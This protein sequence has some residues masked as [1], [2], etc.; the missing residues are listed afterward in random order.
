MFPRKLK[1]VGISLFLVFF[2]FI[3]KAQDCTDATAIPFITDCGTEFTLCVDDEVTDINTPVIINIFSNDNLG[4]LQACDIVISAD[5][6]NGTA[7]VVDGCLLKYTPD[8]NY[9]G[10]DQ[11][12]YKF[13][14]YDVCVDEYCE[15]GNHIWDLTSYYFGPDNTSLEVFANDK[16]IG[17]EALLDD[18]DIFTIDG[19]KLSNADN[20]DW[21]F[22]FYDNDC[23]EAG[24]HCK[25]IDFND[26]DEGRIVNNQ[27]LTEGLTISAVNSG[28]GPDLAIIFNSADPTGQDPDLGTPNEEFNGPG[29][30]TGGESGAGVNDEALFNILII[31]EDAGGSGSDGTVNDPDDEAGGGVITFDFDEPVTVN[32]MKII[33]LEDNEQDFIRCFD[34]SGNL[35]ASITIEGEGDNSVITQAVNVD[36]VSKVEIEFES[37][38]AVDDISYCRPYDCLRKVVT[39][40]TVCPAS[41]G[42]IG[43]PQGDMFRPLSGCVAPTGTDCSNGLF[44][45]P[46]EVTTFQTAETDVNILIEDAGLLPIEFG[47]ISGRSLGSVNVVNWEVLDVVD[48]RYMFLE[49]SID[50]KDY[51]DIQKFGDLA[52]GNYSGT[53]QD[54]TSKLTYYRI[55]SISN[56]GELSFSRSISVFNEDLE[57]EDVEIFP[58]PASSDL[59]FRS[60]SVMEKIEILDISGKRI[61]AKNV[62][63]KDYQI[64][65]EGV[66][67]PGVY[68]ARITNENGTTKT[69]RIVLR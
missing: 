37:S 1:P 26:L 5:P 19:T 7:E 46:V 56:N 68:I 62:H 39:I 47:S 32:D 25:V 14:F 64:I 57:N 38:G 21:E 35:L 58:Q 52:A 34:A 24:E 69:D 54:V 61:L 20:Q 36:D 45:M 27:Y 48:E 9:V 4:I 2:S 13:D 49:K 22:V 63:A 30:G 17:S 41:E 11:F 42:V 59:N 31:A 28:G 51:F 8:F 33:D 15:A 43:A 60:A 53:D 50:G 66:L 6:S 40:P 23:L 16:K 18:G 44:R 67:T 65:V 3:C 10:T 29:V 55:R 12:S